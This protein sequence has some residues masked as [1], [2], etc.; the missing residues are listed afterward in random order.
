MS[1]KSALQLFYMVNLSSKLTFEK[2]H[3]NVSVIVKWAFLFVKCVS[4]VVM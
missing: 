2:W 3:P 4:F 1:Q